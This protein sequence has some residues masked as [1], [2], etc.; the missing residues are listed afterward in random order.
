MIEAGVVEPAASPWSFNVVLV[1][2]PGNPVPR[3]TIDYRA[4]NAIT[5]RDRWS[6]PRVNDCLDALSGSVYFSTLDLSGSFFQVGLEEQDRDKTAFV[7]RKGQFR[8]QTMPMGACNSP[9]VFARLMSMALRGLT[10]L[11]CLVFIDDTI[12]IGRS[13]DEHLANLQAVLQRFRKAN[14]KLKPA[15]CRVFQHRVKFLGHIVSK[16]GIEVDPQK[17]ECIQAWEF[18]KTVSELRTFLGLCSYYRQYCPGYATIVAPLTEMLRKGVVVEPNDRRLRAFEELEQFLSSAPVLAMPTDEG[19]FC[20]DVDSSNFG[21]GA[22]LQQVQDEKLRVLEYASRTFHRAERSY[23][24]TR[25]EMAS[26]IFTLR[27]F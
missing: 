16:E 23:C 19:E 17:V 6:L 7:T 15:K 25:K 20:L 12:V 3:V 11:C 27:H 21:A 22:V 26:L 8:F 13:F 10:Y 5:Y 2:R 1:A 4:L 9:S 18:P 24:I 14:L